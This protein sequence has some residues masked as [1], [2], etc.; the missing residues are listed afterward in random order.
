MTLFCCCFL[1]LCVSDSLIKKEPLWLSGS[2]RTSDA[3]CLLMPLNSHLYRGRRSSGHQNR[4][5]CHADSKKTFCFMVCLFFFSSLEQ[6]EYTLPRWRRTE[7]TSG[8]EVLMSEQQR[9]SPSCSSDVPTR[10][11]LLPQREPPHPHT[12]VPTPQPDTSDVFAL[13]SAG[14][15]SSLRLT[16]ESPWQC[17][18][19]ECSSHGLWLQI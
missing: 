13:Q 5:H 7:T 15:H 10:R 4:R 12:I 3:L 11:G 17:R 18:W 6:S 19:Y 1:P 2:M 16:C 9:E 14:T 8:R